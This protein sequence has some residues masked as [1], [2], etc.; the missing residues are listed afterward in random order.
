M[1]EPS[2]VLLAAIRAIDA[3]TTWCGQLVAWLILPLVAAVTYEVVAR[4][5]FH[6]PTVGPTTLPTCCT[7]H[8][9]CSARR[10]RCAAARTSAPTLFW[11]NYSVRTRVWS[12]RRRIC[13]SFPGILFLLFAS[14]DEAYY[15]WEIGEVSRQT[16]WRPI[17]YPFKAVVPLA[18][19]LLLIRG[20]S[21]LF[22]EPL[23]RA[24]GPSR[25]ADRA[26]DDMSGPELLG[27]VLLIL[28]LG[29]IFIGFPIAFTLLFL[30]FSFGLIGL[31][32]AYSTSP[33]SRSSV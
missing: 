11:E 7:A 3:F 18:A 30:A 14:W 2:P 28:L 20:V 26:P 21:E 12:M 32:N 16:A 27:L 4:H 23:C 33:T 25:R 19:L 5:L 24:H 13:C 8:C 15:A 29:V 17:L 10:T 22:E 1:A 6:T 9:S 31:E